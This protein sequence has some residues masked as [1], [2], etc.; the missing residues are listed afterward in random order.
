MKDESQ[1]GS[2]PE[3][4]ETVTFAGRS[5]RRSELAEMAETIRR[6]RSPTKEHS[7]VAPMPAQDIGL[8]EAV[9]Q[10]GSTEAFLNAQLLECVAIVRDAGWL[11]R[12]SIIQPDERGHFVSQMT[13]MMEA[14]A[15]I[16]AA[17]GRLKGLEDP[18]PTTRQVFEVRY[19]D[20][21]KPALPTRGEGGGVVLENE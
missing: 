6:A 7:N 19:P 21:P 17:I 14:S 16:A 11:Y 10:P 4:A 2:G 1:A 18:V 15:K 20:A 5:Y 12:N 9:F 13:A 8:A 3:D